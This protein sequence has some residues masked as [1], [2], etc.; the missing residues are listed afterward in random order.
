MD[1]EDQEK[2]LRNGNK[3]QKSA[4]SDD[5]RTVN[6]DVADKDVPG[7]ANNDDKGVTK[8]TKSSLCGQSAPDLLSQILETKRNQTHKLLTSTPAG[9]YTTNANMRPLST[10][11]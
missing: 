11:G 2:R 1:A 10:Y 8:K 7:N 6:K 9:V 5:S 4:N 3:S